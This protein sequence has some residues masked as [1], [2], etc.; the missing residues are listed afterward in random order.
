MLMVN[1][2][3]TGSTIEAYSARFAPL[4]PS[5]SRRVALPSVLVPNAYTYLLGFLAIFF[6]EEEDLF[7]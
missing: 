6:F 2:G 5:N 3:G 4:P 1:P 7:A